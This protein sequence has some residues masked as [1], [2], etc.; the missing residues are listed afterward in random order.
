MRTEELERTT[1]FIRLIVMAAGSV[2]STSAIMVAFRL[3]GTLLPI[4]LAGMAA[5]LW[6]GLRS[7]TFL[8]DTSKLSRWE[9]ALL[10]Y[11]CSIGSIRLIPYTYQYVFGE[12]T[13]AATWD[14]N[15]HLQELAS[16][17]TTPSF[18]PRL[19]FAPDFYLHFYYLPWIPAAALSDILLF[20]TG[21]PY[22]KLTY[23]LNALALDFAAS[24][25]LVVFFRHTLMPS[26]R[27]F[28][29][30]ALLLVGAL[31]DG[32]YS[33]WKLTRG[34]VTHSEWWQ[35][36]DGGINQYSTWTTLFIWVPHHLIAATC[37]LLALVVTTEP[38]T[39]LP[40]RSWSAAVAG[41]LLLA[42]A[43]FSSVF[44]TIG[45]LVAFSPL[46][47]RFIKV[48]RFLALLGLTTALVSLPLTHIYLNSDAPGRFVFGAAFT[49]WREYHASYA[50]GFAGIAAT[51]LYM[52]LEVGWLPLLAGMT[53][54]TFGTVRTSLTRSAVMSTGYLISTV[55]VSYEGSN[56]FATRGVIVPSIVLVCFW[57]RTFAA[58][59]ATRKVF[60]AFAGGCAIRYARV[61]AYSAIAL[62]G[63]AH[64]NEFAWFT[65]SS[66]AAVENAT[67]P[68]ACKRKILEANAAGID[69][70]DIAAF[71]D[72]GDNYGF[73]S[74]ERPFQK[75]SLV[76]SDQELMGHGP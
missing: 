37:I 60:D 75:P 52:M 26:E 67:A 68:L 35:A 65:G 55:F 17:V 69:R 38:V 39:L 19:N 46:L 10:A 56:N 15:W 61:A 51:A 11:S 8:E 23:G 49:L 18:P 28:A 40:R 14:D 62:A 53:A 41:G 72:C 73:Y 25:L 74:F 63:V 43:L 76:W 54:M 71:S 32:L 45:G 9:W 21:Q 1:S 24:G 47:V 29:A 34:I 70:I 7:S 27:P 31:P 64:I 44:V 12:L 5:I 20:F 33:I 30:V 59:G 16:L 66:L 50:F 42:S 58:A 6:L 13:G 22:L 36:A 4:I 3:P 48:P 57:A 2:V